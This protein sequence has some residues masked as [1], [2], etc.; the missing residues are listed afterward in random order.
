[1]SQRRTVELEID[2]T[3][4]WA[5]TSLDGSGHDQRDNGAPVRRATDIPAP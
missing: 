4:G 2:P 1:M 3:M 5:T